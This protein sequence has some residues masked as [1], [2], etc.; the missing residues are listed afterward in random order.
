MRFRGHEYIGQPINVPMTADVGT[1]VADKVIKASSC[2]R[3]NQVSRGF[4]RFK[5]HSMSI[6]IKPLAGSTANSGYTAAFI[7]D[8]LFSTRTDKGGITNLTAFESAVIKQNW[9][10]SRIHR[11]SDGA[12]KVPFF[13]DS[14][15]DARLFSPGKFVVQLNGSPNTAEPN[16]DLTF[17]LVCNYDVEL[18]MPGL[19]S[20][21]AN[22]E[23][24]DF[25]ATWSNS[26]LV[27]QTPGL[28]PGLAS[29]SSTQ[30]LQAARRYYVQQPVQVL[31]YNGSVNQS[32][33]V[34]G[35]ATSE[36]AAPSSWPSHRL[37]VT[38]TPDI[39]TADTVNITLQT[40][41]A[42]DEFIFAALTGFSERR[43]TY[44]P[45]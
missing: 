41:G 43:P 8:P 9:V 12:E 4:Q 39:V 25:T 3:L 13:V 5:V 7:N 15:G 14:Q 11:A 45:Q 31:L 30:G 40:T 20:E 21:T 26:G 27:F 1:I 22:E 44:R 37:I 28:P 42:Q 36:T 19:I 23:E 18:F 17:A 24:D 2:P 38:L 16:S 6:D 32:Y 35:F 10:E 33:W 34:V 29:T